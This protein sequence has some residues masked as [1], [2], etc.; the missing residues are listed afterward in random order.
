MRL[1][2]VPGPAMGYVTISCSFAGGSSLDPTARKGLANVTAE[3]A[4]RGTQ[5]ST[6]QQLAR[7][8]EFLGCSPSVGVGVESANFSFDAPTRFLPD[9]LELLSEVFT[10]PVFRPSELT[11][12]KRQLTGEMV[13][14]RD[15][16]SAAASMFFGQ[17][18]YAGDPYGHPIRGYAATLNAITP[19]NVATFR[20][21]H[22]TRHRLLLGVAGSISA[23]EAE[24]QVGSLFEHLPQGAATPLPM[25]P[26]TTCEG[27][28]LLLV[29]KEERS[30]AQVIIGQR[31]IPGDH[32]LMV[33]LRVAVLGFGGTFTSPL[34]REIREKRG[35]SYGV[36][37]GLMAGRR[38]GSF[39]M[40]F[41]PKNDEVA[42]AISL[43]LEMLNELVYKGP[44][45]ETLAFTKRFLVQQYPFMTETPVSRL[46]QMMHV[47]AT[48][49]PSDYL[50]TYCERVQAVEADAALFALRSVLLPAR[51]TV[52]VFGDP[53]LEESLT[54]IPGI[55]RFRKLNVD[56]DAP[57]APS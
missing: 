4:L 14:L 33:P 45:E 52:V 9:L 46:D 37:A 20:S 30:Q 50:D 2:H 19:K 36:S 24:A 34:V 40:R 12:L 39:K 16:D 6:R 10:Q 53:S 11:N 54:K 13:D 29:T 3:L 23:K 47:A 48:N 25:L 15:N 35:W 42:P 44:D 27:L 1:F 32:P 56:Y 22:Y 5:K 7:R 31:A 51:Q 26:D 17:A 43:A 28:D 41:S 38:G 49:K 21:E 8:F 55:A 57:I 18:L